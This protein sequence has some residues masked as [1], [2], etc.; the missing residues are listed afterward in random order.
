VGHEGEIKTARERAGLFDR[1]VERPRQRS[2]HHGTTRDGIRRKKDSS[3]SAPS[4]WCM[5]AG[6]TGDFTRQH[7]R[8][9]RGF[10]QAARLEG[11]ERPALAARMPVADR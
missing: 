7:R 6:P 9:R 10:A 8:A 2:P 5:T 1:R 4:S 11:V 3:M